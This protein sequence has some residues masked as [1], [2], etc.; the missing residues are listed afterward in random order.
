MLCATARTWITLVSF[1]SE[2]GKQVGKRD[3]HTFITCV[4]C[5]RRDFSP[6]EPNSD[7]GERLQCSFGQKRSLAILEES[8]RQKPVPSFVT[9]AC[10]LIRQTRVTACMFVQSCETPRPDGVAGKLEL[11]VSSYVGL[12]TQ[13]CFDCT[14]AQVKL[15]IRG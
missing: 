6:A 4:G 8:T 10:S 15:W 12:S 13:R 9:S 5:F 11:K 3:G 14:E 2:D 7:D 1:C